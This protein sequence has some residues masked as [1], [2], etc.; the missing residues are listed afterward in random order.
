MTQVSIIN[1]LH[2]DEKWLKHILRTA[3][4]SVENEIIRIHSMRGFH[5]ESILPIQLNIN[6]D[7]AHF[8]GLLLG[9]SCSTKQTSAKLGLSN[10]NLKLLHIT[11]NQLEE[12]FLQPSSKIKIQIKV[13][14]QLQEQEMVEI[15]NIFR[16][17]RE[18]INQTIN[19]L[20]K[21][22]NF[23]IFV[24]NRPLKR[25]IFDELIPQIDEILDKEELFSFFGGVLDADGN[26]R[27]DFIAVTL[28][29]EKEIKIISKTIK[30]LFQVNPHVT[31]R[32][33]KNAW[34]LRIFNTTTIHHV[35]KDVIP[36]LHTNKGFDILA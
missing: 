33:G 1:L 32:K 27:K 30:R 36:F 10:T 28:G 5:F 31:I 29:S 24:N 14:R 6:K 23:E 18:N 8:L 35:L 11:R 16:I 3:K 21:Q 7:S 20:C 2:K 9:D 12:T 19:S 22:V 25:V 34:D 26:I 4:I 15:A 13:S 17:G